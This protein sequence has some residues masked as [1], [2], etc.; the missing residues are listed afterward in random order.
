MNSHEVKITLVMLVKSPATG[1]RNHGGMDFQSTQIC[2][3]F[4]PG[5]QWW[6][7]RCV[8]AP[9]DGIIHAH[10]KMVKEQIGG[11]YRQINQ[12]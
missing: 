1:A 6:Y 12:R 3:C 4:Q 2:S 7:V 11:G 5:L 10:I 9:L 8:C